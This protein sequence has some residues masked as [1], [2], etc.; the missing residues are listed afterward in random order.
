MSFKILENKAELNP[1]AT[2][3]KQKQ[4]QKQKQTSSHMGNNKMETERAIEDMVNERIGF[5]NNNLKKKT[6]IVKPL[7]K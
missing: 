3:E 6:E 4:K 1:I 2:N 7:A 5:N